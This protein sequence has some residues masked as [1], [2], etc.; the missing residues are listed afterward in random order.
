MD[1]FPPFPAPIY[2][3]NFPPFAPRSFEAALNNRELAVRR[4]WESRC[5]YLV[6]V[7]TGA[8]ESLRRDGGPLHFLMAYSLKSI[9]EIPPKQE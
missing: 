6:D 8:E 1:Q 5:R 4:Y 3:R 2:G 9:G 7:I